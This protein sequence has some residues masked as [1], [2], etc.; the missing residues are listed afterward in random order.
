MVYLKNVQFLLATLYSWNMV[1]MHFLFFSW[2]WRSIA[3]IG[4]WSVWYWYHAADRCLFQD[5]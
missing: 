5:V 4:H 2:D 3:C 1:S